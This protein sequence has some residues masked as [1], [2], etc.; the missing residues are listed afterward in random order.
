MAARNSEQA[1]GSVS[2][3][4]HWG[5]ALLVAA[6]APVGLIANAMERGPTE[7][8]LFD[9]HFALGALIFLLVSA[10][11]LWRFA[12]PAPPPPSGLGSRTVLAARLAHLA[13]Y[14]ALLAMI[15][16]GYVIQ[17]HMRPALDLFGLVSLPRPFEP[18]EDESLR[19]AAWYVHRYAFRLLL[20]LLALHIAAALWHQ[21]VRRDGVLRRMLP[22]RRPRLM[23]EDR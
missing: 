19:A 16:S 2:Q 8:A 12:D 3:A 23:T 1:W 11:I 14:A 17:I 13:I 18:G 15:A 20:V 5:T 4:F 21:F 6:S 22:W 9:V 7:R 10:R